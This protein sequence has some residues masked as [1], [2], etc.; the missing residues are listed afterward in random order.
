L[1]Y[2]N[3]KFNGD[4]TARQPDGTCVAANECAEACSGEPGTRSAILG[5]CSCDNALTVD[6]ICNQKCRKDSPKTSFKS[7]F[8]IVL[9][10]PGDN[11][12]TEID[13][14]EAGKFIGALDTCRAEDGG[15]DIKH[16]EIGGDGFEGTYKVPSTIDKVI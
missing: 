16:V 8:E 11:S 4:K 12:S 2:D 5:V 14:T 6:E 1:V 7:S 3:C 10:Y 9:T 15:C 13:L